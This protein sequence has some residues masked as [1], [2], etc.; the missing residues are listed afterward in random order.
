MQSSS[1]EHGLFKH[2]S[3]VFGQ[4]QGRWEPGAVCSKQAKIIT[5]SFFDRRY[6]ERSRP[7]LMVVV[8]FKCGV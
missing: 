3:I 1:L 8:V 5:I 2:F 7:V 6:R 4:R